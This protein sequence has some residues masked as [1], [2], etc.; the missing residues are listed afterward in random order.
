MLALVD[1]R[2]GLASMSDC[3]DDDT[4]DDQALFLDE[5]RRRGH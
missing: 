3:F 4:D 1:P 2:G 5:S